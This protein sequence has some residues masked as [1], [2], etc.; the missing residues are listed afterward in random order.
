MYILDLKICH[1]LKRTYA[2]IWHAVENVFKQGVDPAMFFNAV[3]GEKRSA[4]RRRTQNCPGLGLSS[5]VS[6]QDAEGAFK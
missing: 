3:L 1:C 6:L 5:S 2:N 4:Q